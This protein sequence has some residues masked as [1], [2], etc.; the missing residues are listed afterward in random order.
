MEKHHYSLNHKKMEE[1]HSLIHHG[2]E[3]SIKLSEFCLRL[4]EGIKKCL[5]KR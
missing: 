3:A 2:E 5:N 1:R 4:F